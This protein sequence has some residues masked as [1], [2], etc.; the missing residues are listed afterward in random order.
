MKDKRDIITS[1]RIVEL[2]VKRK[3]RK[4]RLTILLVL[5]FASIIVGSSYL[6]KYHKLT[7]QNITV[8][9]TYIIDNKEVEAKVHEDLADNYLYLF[10][11]KNAF[12]YPKSYIEKD[13]Q[14]T[15]P[16]I[17]TLSV[18]LEGLNALKIE[19]GERSGAYLYCGEAIPE[20]ASDVGENCYFI[21]SDGYIFDS[22]PYFSGNIYFKF[23]TP[24]ENPESPLGQNVLDK[25]TFHETIS[26]VEGLIELGFQPVSV[27]RTN[28]EQY[29]FHLKP[30]SG[31]GE[32][33]ILFKREN[34]LPTIFNNLA[35][36]MKKQEFKSQ[37]VANL[38]K[39]L[40]IDLRFNNKVLYKF[41]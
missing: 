6:S 14:K 31:G 21:N 34:D 2:T 20:E 29:A 38:D 23:Y 1:P 5:L 26:F 12:I 18:K 24:I 17:E 40:Y 4:L 35:S 37:M 33:E 39:L 11:K 30:R 9:G 19:I 28:E 41:Q 7:I 36:A 3:K 32:P 27:V 25:D 22:A 16:R 13:L 8:S 15:F 10:A